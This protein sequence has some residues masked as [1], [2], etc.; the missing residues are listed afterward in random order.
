MK[1]PPKGV[2]FKL[3]DTFEVLINFMGTRA[4][5]T[6]LEDFKMIKKDKKG[7][8]LILPTKFNKYIDDVV[9]A[10]IILSEGKKR[11]G[12]LYISKEAYN[13][14]Y[15]SICIHVGDKILLDAYRKKNEKKKINVSEF[16]GCKK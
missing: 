3:D 14:I 8:E 6:V 4:L 13:N 1:K 10:R 7:E 5:I 9:V 15:E 12:K 16:F 2:Y 11:F